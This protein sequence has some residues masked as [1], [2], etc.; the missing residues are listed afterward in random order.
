LTFAALV[1]SINICVKE[2]ALKGNA[3]KILVG[4]TIANLSHN[5]SI[6]AFFAREN[7]KALCII[8]VTIG[9]VQFCAGLVMYCYLL[10]C[11]FDYQL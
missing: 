11:I 7:Y 2:I 3:P 6:K 5:A 10:F 4:C 1:C 8:I 9:V